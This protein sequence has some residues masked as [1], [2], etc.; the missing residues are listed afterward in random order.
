M[1]AQKARYWLLTIPLN[2][3]YEPELKNNLIYLKGQKEIGA[4]GYEHWQLLAVFDKQVTMMQAKLHFCVTAHLEASR[5]AAANE[6]VWKDDTSVAGSRF[7][8]GAL[9]FKRNSKTDW[10]KVLTD[11]KAGRLDDIPADVLVRNYTSLKRI[12]IDNAV[13]PF[14]HDVVVKCYWGGSGLGKTRRAWF[15]ASDDVYVKDPCTKWWD[16]Y[17]GQKNVIIDEFT[18]VIN[19]A[20]ILKW[21]DR[22]PC[23]AEVKGFSTPLLATNFW[24]TSNIDPRDWYADINAEQRNGLIRRM[25]ITH[26][27]GPWTPP[28]EQTSIDFGDEFDILFQ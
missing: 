4:G 5:S 8:L 21:L 10:D 27:L 20:H 3:G 6:Y 25:N 17:K 18:G 12:R 22:Y 26:F 15:E 9:P 13:P 28:T 14:R 24:I 23:F 11:A 16:G 7:E 1:P 19:I 2:S